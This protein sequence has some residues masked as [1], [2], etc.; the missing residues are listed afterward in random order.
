MFF[1]IFAV[2]YATTIELIYG[3]LRSSQISDSTMQSESMTQSDKKSR[4][5]LPSVQ[6]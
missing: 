1:L 5:S 4:V 6:S 2:Y 3:L